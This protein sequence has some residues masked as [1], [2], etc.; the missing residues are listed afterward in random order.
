[1]HPKAD[2]LPLLRR[3]STAKS[4]ELLTTCTGSDSEDIEELLELPLRSE[5]TCVVLCVVLP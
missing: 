2:G 5:V 1:M 4:L 3:I